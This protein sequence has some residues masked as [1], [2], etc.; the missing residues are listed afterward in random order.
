MNE[1]IFGAMV[2]TKI[3]LE[4]LEGGCARRKAI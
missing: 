2:V 4:S 3:V 1:F